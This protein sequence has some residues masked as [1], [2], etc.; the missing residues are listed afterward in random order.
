MLRDCPKNH[1]SLYDIV[2]F[3]CRVLI[4]SDEF[5]ASSELEKP[6]ENKNHFFISFCIFCCFILLSILLFV[7]FGCREWSIL[8]SYKRLVYE[9]YDDD[10]EV[11]IGDFNRIPFCIVTMYSSNC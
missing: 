9:D 11:H 6:K 4:S 5:K 2:K 7:C 3:F 1:W 10:D 8:S